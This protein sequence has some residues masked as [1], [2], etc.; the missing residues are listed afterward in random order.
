MSLAGKRTKVLLS[1]LLVLIL[2]VGA[3]CGESSGTGTLKAG[4]RADIVNFGYLNSESE[5]YYGLEIDI[6]EEM[7][8]RM[9][10]KDVE[11]VTVEP[12]TRK[13]M[14]QDGKV[15]CLVAAY[16]ISDSRKKSF[17]FSEPYYTDGTR[18]MVEKSSLLTNTEDLKDKIV[19]VLSGSNAGP[20]LGQKLAELGIISGQVV[21]DSDDETVYEDITV[22]KYESYD[23][24]S[25][26]LE[27]GEVDAVCMDGCIAGTY[28]D[29]KRELLDLSISEQKYGVATQ[30]DSELS[31]KVDKTIKA[32][33]DDGTIGKLRD[34]WD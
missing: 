8:K 10:Y 4:V 20:L 16:S 22:R 31:K 5:K 33:L 3:G 25:A 30:K 34:K 28:M 7:A 19:G 21:S 2:A 23:A 18:I 15:D 1:A 12:S 26:A 24:L 27:E 29:E 14:L 13:E 32:M 17:D 9:G 6:A 11:Y